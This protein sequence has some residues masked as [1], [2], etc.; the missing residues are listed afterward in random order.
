MDSFEVRLVYECRMDSESSEA[1]FCWGTLSMSKVMKCC[2]VS[3]KWNGIRNKLARSFMSFPLAFHDWDCMW[4]ARVKV[5]DLLQV[6]GS[7]ALAK[8][9]VDNILMVDGCLERKEKVKGGGEVEVLL[10]DVIVNKGGTWNLSSSKIQNQWRKT[11]DDIEEREKRCEGRGQRI[12][13]NMHSY[14]HQIFTDGKSEAIDKT[15]LGDQEQWRKT[16]LKG[17]DFI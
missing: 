8:V 7:L 16:M 5:I 10:W 12:H 14:C 2:C 9:A 4:R 11:K 15:G 6:K 13:I 3:T 1:Y 17:L